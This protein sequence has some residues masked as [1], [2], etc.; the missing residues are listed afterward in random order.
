[1]HHELEPTAKA[2]A[3]DG[4]KE[5]LEIATTGKSFKLK[6]CAAWAY[7]IRNEPSDNLLN[8]LM[9]DHEVVSFAA[10][11]SCKMIAKKFTGRDVNYG[12]HTGADANEKADSRAM[13]ELAFRK[14]SK[15]EKTQPVGDKAIKTI[16]NVRK[17]TAQEILGIE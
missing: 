13:W 2:L 14:Y 8:L 9:D 1:M 4:D 3:S 12:P 6:V 16:G 11:E 15:M 5:M 10:R 17:K 7:G